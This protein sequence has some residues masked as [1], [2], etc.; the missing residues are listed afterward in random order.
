MNGGNKMSPEK[1]KIKAKE[2]TYKG[3]P[4]VRCGNTIYYGDMS[5]KYVV[6]FQIMETKK[7]KDMDVASKV[8]V[9]LMYTDPDIRAKDRIVKKS[10]KDGLYNALDIGCIWLQRALNE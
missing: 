1:E 3:K 8:I 10:E 9:Q 4:L 6:M 2:L 5:D 7:V